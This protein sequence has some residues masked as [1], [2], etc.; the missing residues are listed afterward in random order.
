MELHWDF[1]GFREGVMI[2]FFEVD[3]L[4]FEKVKRE[5]DHSRVQ[6]FATIDHRSIYLGTFVAIQMAVSDFYGRKFKKHQQENHL[7][8]PVV[9]LESRISQNWLIHLESTS[10]WLSMEKQWKLEPAERFF[11]LRIAAKKASGKGFLGWIP[12]YWRNERGKDHSEVWNF[13]TIDHKTSTFSPQ[14]S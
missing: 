4:K 11:I 14:L 13:T 9:I 8:G 7:K 1:L 6:N 12:S 3:Y 2:P 5:G 10:R